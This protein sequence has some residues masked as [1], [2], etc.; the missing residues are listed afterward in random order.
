MAHKDDM[1]DDLSVFFDEDDFGDRVTYTSKETGAPVTVRCIIDLGQTPGGDKANA[2]SNL[3][4]VEIPRIDLEVSPR[5]GDVI[6]IDGEEWSVVGDEAN[7]WTTVSPESNVW[8]TVTPGT[9][10]WQLRG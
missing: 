7:T 6:E 8:T 1:I 9:N 10:T 4:T 5:N 3:A 2:V